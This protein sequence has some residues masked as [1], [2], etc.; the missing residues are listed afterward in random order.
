QESNFRT[1]IDT[2]GNVSGSDV[3]L[4]KMRVGTHL[5]TINSAKQT[6]ETKAQRAKP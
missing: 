5:E 6:K 3:N 2:D 4:T 1:D